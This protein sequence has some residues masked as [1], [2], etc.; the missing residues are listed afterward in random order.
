MPKLEEW[1]LSQDNSNPYQAPEL[2]AVRLHGKVYG[3]ERFEDGDPVTT[4]RVHNLDMKNRIAKTNNTTY[5]LGEPSVEYV[6]W[7]ESNGKN[8]ED[9]I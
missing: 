4:S 1:S 9:Y 5:E 3:H 7:L 2:R 6:E 8:L